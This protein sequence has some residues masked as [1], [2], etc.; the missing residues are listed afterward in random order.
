MIAQG[1]NADNETFVW[2]FVQKKFE[3]AG[4]EIHAQAVESLLSRDVR[5]WGSVS[6]IL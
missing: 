3:A 5:R 6:L 4:R 1:L 2:F